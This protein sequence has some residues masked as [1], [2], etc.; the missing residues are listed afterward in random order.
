MSSLLGH[1]L[2][3]SYRSSL[4]SVRIIFNT[5]K[6]AEQSQLHNVISLSAH[7][8]K[9][10]AIASILSDNEGFPTSM[11]QFNSTRLRFRPAAFTSC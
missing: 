6:Q 11:H 3:T 7:W 9:V 4:L 8:G 10:Y 5:L 1:P 2:K